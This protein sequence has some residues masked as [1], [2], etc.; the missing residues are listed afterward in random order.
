MM[1]QETQFELVALY[2]HHK[3]MFFFIYMLW[4]CRF[5]NETDINN[6]KC[7]LLFV[8]NCYNQIKC[9]TTVIYSES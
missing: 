9:S 1:Q 5:S 7:G 6:T 3:S 4:E 8:F 2:D